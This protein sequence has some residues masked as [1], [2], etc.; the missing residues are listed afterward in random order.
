MKF[1]SIW[2]EMHHLQTRMAEKFELFQYVVTE[3]LRNQ[4]LV[5]MEIT[6]MVMVV[7]VKN[8]CEISTKFQANCLVYDGPMT[9]GDLIEGSGDPDTNL[10]LIIGIV[11]G[12]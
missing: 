7:Q 6:S 2:V 4:K 8:L 12:T 9:T 3:K 5:T 11:I 10:G 1:W